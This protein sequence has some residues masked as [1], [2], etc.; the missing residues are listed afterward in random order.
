[1]K[2][3]FPSDEWINKLSELL[4]A[5]ESYARSAKDWEGDFIFS[6]E[7]DDAYDQ[8]AYFHLELFHGK[9]PGAA[10]VEE[11]NLPETEFIITAPYNTWRRVID[12]KLDPIQGMMTGQLKLKGDLMK[13]MRYPKAA[14]EL[15]SCCADVPTEW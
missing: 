11:E 2:Y 5:S 10:M 9:S 3:K 7:S 13:I 12:G 15:V 1:M 14:Q 8:T 4:N 6:V